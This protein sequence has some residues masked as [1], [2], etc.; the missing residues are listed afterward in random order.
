[1]EP[2]IASMTS[3]T[4]SERRTARNARFTDKASVVL[5]DEATAALLLIPAVMGNC[6]KQL[7]PSVLFLLPACKKLLYWLSTMNKT[8][9]TLI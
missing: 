9:S 4:T 3:A 8:T 5:P 7:L 1:M 6:P 2:A